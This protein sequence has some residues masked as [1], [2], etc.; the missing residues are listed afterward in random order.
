[1][2]IVKDLLK[3]FL[4]CSSLFWLRHAYRDVVIC[5]S[6]LEKEMGHL[7]ALAE[8]SRMR[9]ASVRGL[10]LKVSTKTN[11]WMMYSV[12]SILNYGQLPTGSR[13]LH[14]AHFNTEHS[15]Q[16]YRELLIMSHIQ[17]CRPPLYWLSLQN[18]HHLSFL[19]SSIPQEFP[20]WNDTKGR[21]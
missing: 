11:H 19:H 4:G 21:T 20:A 9:Y 2:W 3:Y 17:S 14:S 7:L 6:I 8:C 10:N 13:I 12:A 15:N 5:T 1:M 18:H 16:T